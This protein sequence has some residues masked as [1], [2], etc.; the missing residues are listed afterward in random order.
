MPP[1]AGTGAPAAPRPVAR[2]AGRRAGRGTDSHPARCS[3]I[4]SRRAASIVPSTRSDRSSCSWWQVMRSTIREVSFAPC[5]PAT[6]TCPR[7]SRA[8]PRPRDDRTLRRR[9]AGTPPGSPR[10]AGRSRAPVQAGSTSAPAA[11][12]RL[13]VRRVV[14]RVRLLSLARGPAP[15]PIQVHVHRQPIQPRAERRLALVAADAPIGLQEHVLDRV[16]RIGRVAEHAP[17]QAV[18]PRRVHPVDLLEGRQIAR[19]DAFRQGGVVRSE[20]FG[21]V[22]RDPRGNRCRGSNAAAPR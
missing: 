22:R 11:R 14:E 18:Q 4:T 17:R 8:W 13:R 5:A 12:D 3:S 9:A 15:Q 7:Q 2:D 19:R 1:A 6:S 20:V 10:G 16:F 21:H